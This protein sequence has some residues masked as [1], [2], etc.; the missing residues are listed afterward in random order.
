MP[1]PIVHK[2]RLR[3]GQ[4]V[5][6]K[7]RYINL[8]RGRSTFKQ[9]Q[10]CKLEHCLHSISSSN[11][12]TLVSLHVVKKIVI[13]FFSLHLFLIFDKAHCFKLLST[14]VLN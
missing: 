8:Q 12:P 10:S 3:I 4:N 11:I 9:S 2:C 5:H 1:L 14:Y 6:T 13:R 7:V